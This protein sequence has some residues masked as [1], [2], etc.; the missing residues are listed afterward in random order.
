MGI[1]Y[2]STHVYY[3]LYGANFNDF[4]RLE[5][6][7]RLKKLK[8]NKYFFSNGMHTFDWFDMCLCADGKQ[9]PTDLRREA[10]EIESA[11]AWQDSG[12]EGL[13]VSEQDDEYRFLVGSLVKLES[14]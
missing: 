5:R 6:L 12:G 8:K 9:I 10:A 7:N 14:L 13:E 2:L 4:Y 1:F 11:L 3:L